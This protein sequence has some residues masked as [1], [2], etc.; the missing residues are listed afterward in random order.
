[1]DNLKK[2]IL[3]VLVPTLIAS[4]G[5]SERE[6]PTFWQLFGKSESE[7]VAL[8]GPGECG[9]INFGRKC[10]YTDPAKT[11][12]VFKDGK[13]DRITANEIAG[14]CEGSTIGIGWEPDFRSPDGLTLRWNTVA[15]T[16]GVREISLFC[17]NLDAIDYVLI[18]VGDQN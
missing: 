5:G 10:A 4:C 17:T 6:R 15:K 8:L 16:W 13:A 14:S 7:S 1:M 18:Y 3:T 2:L 11:E 12:I 9:E